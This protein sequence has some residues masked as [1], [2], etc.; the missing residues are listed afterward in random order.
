MIKL[1]KK[2]RE[3]MTGRTGEERISKPMNLNNKDNILR[4]QKQVNKYFKIYRH[5]RKHIREGRV[6]V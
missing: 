5:M 6:A 2:S 3:I 1:G 4:T